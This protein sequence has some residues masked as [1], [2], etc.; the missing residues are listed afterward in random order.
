M[1]TQAATPNSANKQLNSGRAVLTGH[2]MYTHRMTGIQMCRLGKQTRGHELESNQ[3]MGNRAG[4]A[5]ADDKDAFVFS[6]PRKQTRAERGLVLGKWTAVV[7]S[8]TLGVPSMDVVGADS[9]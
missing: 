7:V 6:D 2:D 4:R 3:I 1:S 9:P 5:R 8:G